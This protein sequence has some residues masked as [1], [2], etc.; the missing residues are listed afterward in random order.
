[1]RKAEIAVD[2]DMYLS[3][4]ITHPTVQQATWI[5]AKHGPDHIKLYTDLNDWSQTSRTLY[6]GVLARKA[7]TSFSIRPL[8]YKKEGS[9]RGDALIGPDTIHQGGRISNGYSHISK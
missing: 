6:I 3:A 4:H 8:V 2:V 9:H 7:D 5:A 1:M